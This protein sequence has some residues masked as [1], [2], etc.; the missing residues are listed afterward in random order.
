MEQGGRPD[1]D[2]AGAP[3]GGA[4]RASTVQGAPTDQMETAAGPSAAPSVADQRSTSFL[5]PSKAIRELADAVNI[6][7]AGSGG[8]I[9]DP[10]EED[11]EEIEGVHWRLDETLDMTAIDTDLTR[12]VELAD[13]VG[14][15]IDIG[16]GGQIRVTDVIPFVILKWNPE[17]DRSWTIPSPEVF[18]DLMA[19]VECVSLESDVVCLRAYR[20]ANLWG[21]VGLLGLSSSDLRDLKE[22]REMIENQML[23]RTRFTL[24]PKDALERRG[25]LSVLLRANLRT[26]D[27]KWLPKAILLRS[28]MKGG[29]KLTHV[30]YYREDDKTR[31]GNSKK[32]WRLALLQGCPQFMD[33][34]KKFD[35]EHRFP[36]GAGHIIIR[37]GADRPKGTVERGRGSR[38]GG[39]R[40]QQQHQQQHQQQ[41]DGQQQHQQRDRDRQNRT[42]DRTYDRNYPAL[43]RGKERDRSSGAGGGNREQSAHA[44]WGTNAPGTRR[45]GR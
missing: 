36:I 31:E 22:Y 37:G 32:G 44:A 39:R 3:T 33:S 9:F 6:R 43:G 25:N 28:R 35:Q 30:K 26:F 40:Q 1:S 42:T 41:T 23:G 2:T 38:G 34:L 45:S 16:M 24:F 13:L 8:D 5:C 17:T 14:Q 20:W 15:D 7:C 10:E 29:L 4:D 11:M 12:S 19:R 27:L 18:E 21:K